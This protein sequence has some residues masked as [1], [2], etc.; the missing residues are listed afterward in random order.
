MFEVQ[1]YLQFGGWVNAW[2]W[3]DPKTGTETP[4]IFATEAEAYEELSVHLA[5]THH[6]RD[7]YR[8]VPVE[9]AA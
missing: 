9:D 4:A 5:M 8:V 6:D 7:D 2:T 1:H 3:Y